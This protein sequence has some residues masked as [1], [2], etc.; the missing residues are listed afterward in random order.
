[1][2][3]LFLTSGLVLCLACP[4]FA[5]P[6]P[7]TIINYADNTYSFAGDANLNLA[8]SG[9]VEPPLTS[10]TETT[11]YA[12]WDPDHYSVTYYGGT[13]G[14]H[15]LDNST[16]ITDGNIEF[17]AA[18]TIKN[19]SALST[20]FAQAGYTFV[21]WRAN[22]D[23]EENTAATISSPYQSGGQE[24]AAGATP[25]FKVPNNN[26]KLYAQ[27]TPNKAKI[28]LDSKRYYTV[29]EQE[30]SQTATS[31][32]TTDVWT[33][34]EGA[35]YAN[36]TNAVAQSTPITTIT[37]P[38]L[39]G[40]SFNGYYTQKGGE[41]TSYVS[42]AGAISSNLTTL[43]TGSAPATAEADTASTTLYAYWTANKYT[44][45]YNCG[46]YTNGNIS[47]STDDGGGILTTGAAGVMQKQYTFD[48]EGAP[49]IDPEDVCALE[50]YKPSAWICE[51]E[52][53][54][55][56]PANFTA[57]SVNY[58]NNVLSENWSIPANVNCHVTWTPNEIELTWETGGGTNPNSQYYAPGQGTGSCI[59]DA[60]INV[61]AAPEKAGYEFVGWTTNGDDPRVHDD[62]TP[63]QPEN[64]E[65]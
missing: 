64:V 62:A 42:S 37:V 44:L 32:G 23:I 5:D 17:D 63:T 61:G 30:T 4:A 8:T 40:Y 54:V 51:S 20:P 58:E 11:F 18:Y 50:G 3:K 43:N 55:N 21:N 29:D 36:N 25:L 39:T 13:A 6:D 19:N 33:R 7:D 10:D 57:G 12:M 22:Y 46:S 31:V 15:T 47:Y 45:T 52:V 9:C 41:G 14:S 2:K 49:N 48:G 53:T 1:M 60:G 59:Y 16:G 27:W 56:S 26:V 38:T 34:F 35:I 28:V 65:P 24:Y